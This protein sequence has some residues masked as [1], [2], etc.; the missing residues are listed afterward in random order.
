MLTQENAVEIRVLARQGMGIKEF[1]K[2]LGT[3]RNTVREYLHN[4]APVAYSPRE[5]RPTK[6]DPYKVYLQE[7]I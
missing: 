3:S 1:A 5:R 6:L 2:E 7:R 4:H